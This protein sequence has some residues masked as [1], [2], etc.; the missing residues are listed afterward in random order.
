M[1]TSSQAII[2]AE[3]LIA[4]VEDMN[5]GTYACVFSCEIA[6]RYMLEI[7]SHERHISG[8]PFTTIVEPADSDPRMTTAT[9]LG[10][11]R[12]LVGLPAS[13]VV[14]SRDRFGNERRTGGDKYSVRVQGALL[15]EKDLMKVIDNENG[16]YTISYTILSSRLHRVS[17]MLSNE[18][19]P[20]SPFNVRVLPDQGNPYNCEFLHNLSTLKAGEPANFMI[21]SKNGFDE[22]RPFGGE[23]FAARASSGS[24]EPFDIPLTDHGDGSYLGQ[25]I[26]VR[27]GGYVLEVS[28]KGQPLTGSPVTINVEPGP[29]V[30]EYCTTTLENGLVDGQAQKSTSFTVYCNDGY[31]NRRAPGGDSVVVD[32]LT[33]EGNSKGDVTDMR[34]GTYVVKFIVPRA[35]LR[36]TVNVSINGT[37]LSGCPFRFKA[38][39]GKA[40]PGGR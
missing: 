25:F 19:I 28:L 7:T 23:K 38:A 22:R 17:V 27:A 24:F 13:I 20:G 30:V 4:K 15:K 31:G 16:T 9:G 37:L 40:K 36:S 10:L 29:A 34:D 12:A 33:P 32:I 6:G 18:H 14:H 21:I 11:H 2:P 5:N 1:N 39:V 35:I 3:G 8:S 26:L